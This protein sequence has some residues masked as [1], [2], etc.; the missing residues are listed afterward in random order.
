MRTQRGTTPPAARSFRPTLWMLGLPLI[1]LSLGGADAALAQAPDPSTATT[2]S[3]CN[4]G[5]TKG[6]A[7]GSCQVPMLAGCVVAD[8]P[9]SRRPWSNI[10]KGGTTTCR[11][12]EKNTDWKSQITGACEKCKTPQCTARFG[13]M[14]DC[15]AQMP[16]PI[17]QQPKPK[18]K[19]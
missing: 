19:P 15:S 10:S 16:P 6:Q 11:F 13:V 2:E 3:S 7:K 4:F 8:F 12:D 18:A 5:M 1:L 9:G 17:S 14:F